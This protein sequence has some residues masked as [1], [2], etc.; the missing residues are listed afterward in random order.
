MTVISALL[1]VFEP[2][3]FPDSPFFWMPA[4]ASTTATDIDWLYDVMVLIAT[5]FAVGIF[6]AMAW[7]CIKY[8]AKDRRSNEVV[9]KT[10]DHNTTLE[11][12]WSLIPMVIMIAL[13]VWGFK[14][15][16]DLRTTPK[17]AQEVHVTAQKW[18]WLFDYPKGISDDALHVPVNTNVRV[19][20]SSVDVLHSF[21]VANFRVKMDAVPGRYTELWFH[22]TEPGEYPI[23]CAEY[24]GTNHSEM[25]TKVVVH[26]PGGYEKWLADK[27]KQME[28]MDPVQL[29]TMLYNQLGCG[30]CHSLD[31]TRLIGPSFKGLWGKTETLADGSSVKV[32]ENYIRQSLLEPQAQL[33]AGY[34]PAMPTFQGKLSDAKIAGI[35]A[36]M[37][38]L[39]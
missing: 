13:F 29:G 18:K 7:F 25:H 19:V 37:K 39:K 1:N 36:Y 9:E 17:D 31:G 22:A 35:I 21:F 34:A 16:V 10:P 28:T 3:K 11:I 24:C 12:T 2:P 20:L 8:R 30:T 38:T 14:G 23:E 33:V 27:E 4:N 26:E 15:Y 5:L 32:D 6:A